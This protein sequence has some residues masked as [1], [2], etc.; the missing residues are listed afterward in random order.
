MSTPHYP[1]SRHD[2]PHARLYDHDLSH[3]AWIGLSGNAH[4]LISRFLAMYRPEKPNSFAAGGAT[5]SQLIG[6]DAKTAKK[7]IDE[8]VVKGHLRIERKGRNRGSV[9]T[10][11]RV[12]SL[13]RFD[14]ETHAGDAILPIKVWREKMN[15]ENLPD[16]HGKKSPSENSRTLANLSNC[17]GNVVPLK[18]GSTHI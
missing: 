9:R 14:T 6:V 13:T 11:E 8:L 16:K 15:R 12:V 18:N 17:C 1:S 5:I 10:R 2:R 3:P 7:L 4:K